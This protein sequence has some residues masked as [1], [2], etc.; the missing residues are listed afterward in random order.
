V[1]TRSPGGTQETIRFAPLSAEEDAAH[2]FG[3]LA[4]FGRLDLSHQRNGRAGR[5]NDLAG[6]F[7]EIASFAAR[8]AGAPSDAPKLQRTARARGRPRRSN[9]R[10]APDQCDERLIAAMR[11]HP[12]ASIGKLAEAIGKSRTSAVTALHRLKDA[13]LAESLGRVW[14]LTDGAVDRA[15]QRT[16]GSTP[17]R[18]GRSRARL[19]ATAPVFPYAHMTSREKLTSVRNGR[20]TRRLGTASPATREP[21]LVWV[22]VRIDRRSPRRDDNSH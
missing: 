8:I 6:S 14:S 9:E 16:R 19:G 18:A 21:G 11:A 12:G 20:S 5:S 2:V 13:N 10:E 17:G 4:R 1:A 3:P 15:G 22:F 7:P